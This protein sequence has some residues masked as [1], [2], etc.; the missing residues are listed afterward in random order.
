MFASLYQTR[1][2]AAAG[3]WRYLDFTFL[4]GKNAGYTLGYPDIY[5]AGIHFAEEP[6][7]HVANSIY[8]WRTHTYCITPFTVFTGDAD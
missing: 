6:K 1:I 4:S 5:L 7:I 8:P 3:S 2:L